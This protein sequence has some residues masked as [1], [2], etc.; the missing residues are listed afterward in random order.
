LF[1]FFIPPL[2]FIPLLFFFLL[3]A[4]STSELQ[5]DKTRRNKTKA[6][7]E[8]RDGVFVLIVMLVVPFADGGYYGLLDSDDAGSS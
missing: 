6:K 8:R 5:H 2:F 4:D 3:L 1:F 7:Q